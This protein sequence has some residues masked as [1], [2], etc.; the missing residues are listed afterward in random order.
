VRQPEVTR[1]AGF[2]VALLLA[3]PVVRA[4]RALLVAGLFLAE[5]LSGGSWPALSRLTAPPSREAVATSGPPADRYTGPSR[6]PRTPLVLV[7]GLAPDGKDDVRLAAAAALLARAGFDVA[8]P[9]V[10]GLTRLRLRPEDAA[11]VVATIAWQPQPAAVVGVSVGAGVAVLASAEPAV[12]DR[13]RLVVSLGG[14]ASAAELVRFY[15]T[16]EYAWGDVRGRIARN[17]DLIRMFLDANADILDASARRV[18]AAGDAAAVDASLRAL[19]PELRALL[20]RLSPERAV[21]DVAAPLLL[22][23]GRTDPAVPY[24]ESLRLAAA[25]PV[26]THVV[27]V[28]LLGHVEGA[29]MT[30]R[31]AALRDLV[32]LWGVAYRLISLA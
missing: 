28:G 4:A 3:L 20:E 8:V 6:G 1:L 21:R 30:E 32:A 17:P 14:Y 23:H 29:D 24:T 18:L 13:V 19:S 12:R 16:G 9:T 11:A 27:L 15:L 25:R 26:H 22:V 10:P 5:F 31:W 2:L 7:H